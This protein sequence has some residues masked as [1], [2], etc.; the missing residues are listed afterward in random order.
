MSIL[1]IAEHDNHKLKGSTLNTV[2]AASKLTGEVSLLIA[3]SGIDAVV[4][5]SQTLNE[6]SKIVTCD[7]DVYENFIAEDLS[8]LVVAISDGYTHILAPSS[9][10]GKNLMPRVAAKLDTQQISDIISVLSLNKILYFSFI[11]V[12]SEIVLFKIILFP[13]SSWNCFTKSA[14]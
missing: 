1:V 11:L 13:S 3:G 2:A 4:S 7:N 5:E 14:I 6:I 12:I 8:Y 9:T 10:F